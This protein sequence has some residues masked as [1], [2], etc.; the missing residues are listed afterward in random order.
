[1]CLRKFRIDLQ[2]LDKLL[3]RLGKLLSVGQFDA[4]PQMRCRH[5]LVRWRLIHP[6]RGYMAAGLLRS[7]PRNPARRQRNGQGQR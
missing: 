1:M 4:G 2:S 7:R 3:C 5:V 6:E